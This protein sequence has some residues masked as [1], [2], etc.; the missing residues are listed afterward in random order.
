[1]KRKPI[2]DR[3]HVMAFLTDIFNLSIACLNQTYVENICHNVYYLSSLNFNIPYELLN[4]NVI[5]FSVKD[6]SFPAL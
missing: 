2:R 5:Y 3:N 4:T 1:M 6:I